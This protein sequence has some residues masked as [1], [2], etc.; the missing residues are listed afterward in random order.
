MRTPIIKV[1][2]VA[3]GLL[4]GV[5]FAANLSEYEKT[6]QELGFKKRTPAYG[7]CVLE[8][9]RRAKGSQ[10]QGERVRAEQQ[11]RQDAQQQQ[12][13][14]EE[15]LAR[16]DGSADH[17]TCYQYGFRLGTP[18]YA[19]CRQKIDL[20]RQDLAA[21]QRAYDED[22]RRYEEQKVAYEKEVE[23]QK[24]LREANAWFNASKFFFALGSGTS[25]HFSENVANAGRA[26]S[27]LPPV[28]PTRPQMQNYSIT[29]PGNRTMNCSAVNN[30]IRCF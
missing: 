6:C 14:Q 23:R 3:L 10:A 15:D 27:G 20:A 13:A 5:V 26:M 19:E 9:D 11:Q 24:N 21:R 4:G 2:L 22:M 30:L 1:A 17:Q 28:P 12:R 7:E 18:H 8:L 29:L 25:P 16:G